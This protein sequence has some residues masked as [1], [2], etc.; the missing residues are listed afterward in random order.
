MRPAGRTKKN[1][2]STGSEANADNN[3]RERRL[4]AV[5]SISGQ[6]GPANGAKPDTSHI[7]GWAVTV[8]VNAADILTIG[9]SSLSGCENVSDFASIVRTA[10]THLLSFIG[11][12]P[13]TVGNHIAAPVADSAMAL[14]DH[15]AKA[16]EII[17]TWLDKDGLIEPAALLRRI[18]ASPE[19]RGEA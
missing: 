7:D 13:D 10:A 19:K 6:I 8:N 9:H 16:L 2:A 18:A 17:A 11:D 15:D 14:T 1:P 5:S 4:S 12:G 3:G